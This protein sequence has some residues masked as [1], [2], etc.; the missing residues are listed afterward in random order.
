M[1]TTAGVFTRQFFH[2]TRADLEPGD[3]IRVGYPSTFTT[4]EPLSWVYFAGTLDAAI[5]GAELALGEGPE[6]IYVVEPTGPIV[7]DPNVTDKKFAG[8]PTL[9]YRSLEPLR[10]VAEVTKW[11]GHAPERL[12]QMKDNL[13]RLKAEGRDAIID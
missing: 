5:W 1:S 9:S 13:A 12:Q 11:Q 8:N 2:G 10:V 7:D 4:G 6:R 3:T